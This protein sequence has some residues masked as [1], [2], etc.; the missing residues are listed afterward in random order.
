[1]Y[2]KRVK[3]LLKFDG[4]TYMVKKSSKKVLE[5]WLKRWSKN[6][7]KNSPKNG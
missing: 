3:N 4:I 1:M 5:K 2:K 6:E 7:R